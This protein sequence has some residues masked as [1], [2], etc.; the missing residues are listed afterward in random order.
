MGRTQCSLVDKAYGLRSVMPEKLPAWME[1]SW[2]ENLGML[3]P[4]SG[5]TW[6][7]TSVT[8]G[9]N[10][11]GGTIDGSVNYEI[12]GDLT[13]W[14]S[15]TRP[16]DL[17]N[18]YLASISLVYANYLQQCGRPSI[19]GKKR[20]WLDPCRCLG[21]WGIHGRSWEIRNIPILRSNLRSWSHVYFLFETLYP[22]P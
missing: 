18:L 5:C 20:I 2:K 7:W 9:E 21:P 10:E 3:M 11:Q 13:P 22:F 12:Y 15:Q 14:S 17:Y 16:W 19:S 4:V 6:L 1:A 8:H